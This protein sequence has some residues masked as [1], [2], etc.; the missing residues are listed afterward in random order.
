MNIYCLTEEAREF[1]APNYASDFFCVIDARTK[2]RRTI[3]AVALLAD[4]SSVWRDART[5]EVDAH[6]LEAVR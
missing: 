3:R 2:G 6:E 4:G 1:F 5:F